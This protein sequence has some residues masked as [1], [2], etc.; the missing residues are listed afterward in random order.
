MNEGAP[1]SGPGGSE[2]RTG[3]WVLLAYRVPREPSRPRIAVWR[4]LERL[5]VARLGDGLVGLPA[6]ARTR[7][8]IGWIADEVMEAGG[9]ATVWLAQPTTRTQEREIAKGMRAARAVEY[10]ALIDQA[11]AAGTETGV[12]RTRAVR[13]LRGELRQ[14]VRRDFFPPPQRDLAKA[15]VEALAVPEPAEADAAREQR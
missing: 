10:Q 11:A 14:I 12:E 7:E 6:D 5:G 13:R 15:A 8:Q 3:S 2:G 4:K 9:A 1:V